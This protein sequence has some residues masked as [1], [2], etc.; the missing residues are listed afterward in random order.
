MIGP[1]QKKLIE[2]FPGRSLKL[3][4]AATASCACLPASGSAGPAI[5]DEWIVIDV[6]TEMDGLEY[7]ICICV[8][9][10]VD[11]SAEDGGNMLETRSMLYRAITRAVMMAMAVNEL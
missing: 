8:G 4:D 9:L 11:M 2:A 1:L 6:M 10:D 7:L 3:V 5:D